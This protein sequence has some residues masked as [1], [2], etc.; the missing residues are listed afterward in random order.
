M[1]LVN[2]QLTSFKKLAKFR[3]ETKERQLTEQ[4][5]QCDNELNWVLFYFP[6]LHVYQLVRRRKGGFTS[7]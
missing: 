2:L 3:G 7:N 1:R 6:H 4:K 5:N